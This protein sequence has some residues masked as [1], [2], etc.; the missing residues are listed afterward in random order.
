MN[1][2]IDGRTICQKQRGMPVY[3]DNLIRFLAQSRPSDQF[4]I[5]INSGFEHNEPQSEYA[6]RLARIS[7]LSNVQIIDLP[8][9]GFMSWE[10]WLLP[11][12][13][14]KLHIDLL[15]MPANRICLTTNIPQIATLHDAM[16]W[17]NLTFPQ[18]TLRGF[19][20]W[21]YSVRKYLYVYFQY[22]VGLKK[23][24]HIV[25]ISQYALDDIT[26][27]F[28]ATMNKISFVYH[29]LPEKFAHLGQPLPSSQ[30]SH[31]LMLGGESP[32]KNPHNMILAYAALPDKLRH[33][34]PLVIIG[35]NPAHLDVFSA[36]VAEQGISENCTLLTWVD[37]SVLVDHFV[38]AT[39]LLFASVEEGFGFPLI[40]AM[41]A[42][43]PAV[44]SNATVLRELSQGAGEHADFHDIDALTYA[45]STILSDPK[46]WSEKSVLMAQHAQA[47][48]WQASVAKLSSIYADKVL[49]HAQ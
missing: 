18:W 29:G 30:R 49:K 15:H 46:Y 24:T 16:E 42:G 6:S 9:E 32:H 2:A 20:G 22:T 13:L 38:H 11:K 43:T 36:W 12:A 3:C 28:P 17:K 14:K 1:I 27:T 45:L 33:Q 41:A 5:F 25:T 44:L 23:L 35:I 8:A 40:Q 48:S 7:G 4:F 31:V 21:L 26:A 34:Y 39:V 47:F 10:Q 37:E 19:R